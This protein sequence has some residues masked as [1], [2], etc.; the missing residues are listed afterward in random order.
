MHKITNLWQFELN[1]TTKSQ[2]NNGRKNGVVAQSVLSGLE[3]KFK[4]FIQKLLRS[5]KLNTSEGAISH[6][7]LYYQ[8]LSINRWQVSIYANNYFEWLP[9]VYSAFKGLCT[10][11]TDTKHNVHRFTLN[12]H[13]FEANDS[14]KLP[15]KYYLRMCCSFCLRRQDFTRFSKTTAPQ[16]VIF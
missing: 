7:I 10:F 14:K 9:I 8:Q 4:Y 12:S 16:L 13:S 15:L 3:I 2:E 11:C 5:R 6:K 1:R